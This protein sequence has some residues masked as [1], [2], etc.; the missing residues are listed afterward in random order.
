MW[1]GQRSLA[2]RECRQSLDW[3]VALESRFTLWRRGF[4][5]WA[6]VFFLSTS[7]ISNRTR[8]LSRGEGPASSGVERSSAQLPAK[9]G[10][11]AVPAQV[12]DA[13]PSVGA[14]EQNA[15]NISDTWI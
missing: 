11:F 14:L 2:L 7:D 15:I 9:C 1:G 6:R 12:L 13:G 8:V 4:H 5:P 10:T 3:F